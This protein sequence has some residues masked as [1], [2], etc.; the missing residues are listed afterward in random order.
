MNLCQNCFDYLEK[1]YGKFVVSNTSLE[2][3]KRFFNTATVC[4][5]CGFSVAEVYVEWGKTEKE[6]VKKINVIVEISGGV[7]VCATT[8]SDN[9][10]IT[11]IDY[12]VESVDQADLTRLNTCKLDNGYVYHDKTNLAV[13]SQEGTVSPE[14]VRAMINQIKQQEGE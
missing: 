4:D 1:R 9:V 14:Y 11:C 12:D 2:I 8:D 3:K 13:V 6:E 10:E 5:S 7:L